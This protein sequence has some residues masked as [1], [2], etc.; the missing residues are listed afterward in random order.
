MMLYKPLVSLFMVFAATSGV[1]ASATPVRRGNGG[2]PPIAPAIP[3]S[4]C[5]ASSNQLCCDELTNVENPLV[6]AIAILANP[7]LDVALNC[8]PIVN[9][10][11]GNSW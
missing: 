2:Y 9:A 7:T 10:V 11:A 6:A 1:A 5:S 4:G 3:A 8:I